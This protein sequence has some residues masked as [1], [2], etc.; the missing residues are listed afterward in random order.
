[1]ILRRVAENLKNQHWTAIAIEFV[2]VILGV[3]IGLQASNWN[4]AR[5][6][7]ARASAY[8]AQIAVD[9]RELQR[10]FGARIKYYHDAHE[11]GLRAVRGLE[12]REELTPERSWSLILSLYQ[13][14]QY[15]PLNIASS[16]Y[17]EAKGS[18][19]M[20]SLGDDDLR[21]ELWT[22]FELSAVNI[23]LIDNAPPRYRAFIRRRI[24][25]ALQGPIRSGDCQTN[26]M[27]A[28]LYQQ[29]HLTNCAAPK[30]ISSELL[31]SVARDLKK[32]PQ[33]VEELNGRMSE[34]EIIDNDYRN[35]QER[36]ARLAGLLEERK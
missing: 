15:W 17:D 21:K 29:L 14:G 4:E 1:M 2:I 16:S 19:A 5:A 34:L 20:R 36:A 31:I 12:N 23:S 18:G 30:D 35:F 26:S 11:F 27:T 6:E 32:D 13:A 3:F 9:L 28:D 33:V 25:W 10:L 24:P 7:K 22:F 8:R